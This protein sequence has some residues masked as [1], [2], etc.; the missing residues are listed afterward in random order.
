MYP[1]YETIIRAVAAV[2][3]VSQEDILGNRRRRH[4]ADAR[5]AVAYLMHTNLRASNAQ[6]AAVLRRTNPCSAAYMHIQ[7]T[8]K[9]ATDKHYRDM[10]DRVKKLLAVALT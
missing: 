1:N 5:H 9:Y 3:P 6:I 7:A 2:F 8:N 4:E 10:V